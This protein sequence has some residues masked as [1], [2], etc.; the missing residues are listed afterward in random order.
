MVINLK[1]KKK[2]LR[3]LA[4]G[5]GSGDAVSLPSHNAA[6]GVEEEKPVF[7]PAGAA[8]HISVLGVHLY[9]FAF[10]CHTDILIELCSC[11]YLKLISPYENFYV[12]KKEIQ[13]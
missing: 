5:A 10:L 8:N 1:K 2:K 11:P 12:I 4:V 6:E 7:Q 3:A 9:L 13:L